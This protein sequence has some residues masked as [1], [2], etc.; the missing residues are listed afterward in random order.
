MTDIVTRPT[1]S[2]PMALI[3]SAVEHGMSPDQLGK[4]MDLQERWAANQAAEA[5]AAALTEF[6]KTCPSIHKGRT[7]TDGK[8]YASFDDVM[9]VAAPRL[10]AVGLCVSF[11][12][13]QVPE[14]KMLNIVTILRHGIHE[15]RTRFSCPVPEMRVN[16]TQRM[17]AAL[18]YA[19]RYGLCA[20]LNLVVT[21]EDS[22]GSGL[23]AGPSAPITEEQAITLREIIDGNGIDGKAFLKWAAVERLEDIPASFYQAA[24]DALKRKAKK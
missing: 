18:S 11:D 4:L 9:R 24:F 2:D 1:P 17:G 3:A 5:F 10:A 13:E 19:K 16:E 21:D 14:S 15:H 20:A 6:Q 23:G 22:D 12:V 7:T 8:A